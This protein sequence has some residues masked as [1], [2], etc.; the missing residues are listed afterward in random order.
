MQGGGLIM[1]PNGTMVYSAEGFG[2]ATMRGLQEYEGQDHIAIWVGDGSPVT[3]G[4]GSGYNL[5]LDNTYSVVANLY[6]FLHATDYEYNEF[7]LMAQ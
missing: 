6:V 4:H 1:N 3:G 5:L 7:Q 2:E